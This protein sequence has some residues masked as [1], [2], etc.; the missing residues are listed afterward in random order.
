MWWTKAKRKHSHNRF[1]AS[2]RLLILKALYSVLFVQRVEIYKNS[3]KFLQN[4][5]ITSLTARSPCCAIIVY[6]TPRPQL[7]WHHHNW[8]VLSTCTSGDS[9]GVKPWES[10]LERQEWCHVWL[11]FYNV[12]IIQHIYIVMISGL[13]DRYW[14][15]FA[16][17]LATQYCRVFPPGCSRTC[18][19]ICMFSVH[20]EAEQLG[21][22]QLIGESACMVVF[23]LPPFCHA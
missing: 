21:D 12:K 13:E 14:L 18:I 3:R 7:T 22:H 10:P 15:L 17:R 16:P 6:T 8:S 23:T 2:L 19:V 5:G 1:V 11:M 4:F 20:H 9:F